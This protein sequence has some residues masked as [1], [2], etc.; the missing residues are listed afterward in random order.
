MQFETDRGALGSTVISQLSAGRK[1][2]LWIEVDG[3][4]ESLAFDQ[5]EPETLWCRPPRVGHDPQA[6]PRVPVRARRPPGLRCRPATRRATGTAS[7]LFVADA[8]AA[9]RG[10]APPDGLPLFA[11]G[12]RTAR[13]PTRS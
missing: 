8:Y 3:S 12:L 7:T 11:D 6:R 1:N 9:I 4:E 5:E 2:R 10:D 13:S